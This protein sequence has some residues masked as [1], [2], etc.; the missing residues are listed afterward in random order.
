MDGHHHHS[1]LDAFGVSL[2]FAAAFNCDSMLMVVLFC[3]KNVTYWLSCE[4]C[5]R[6]DQNDIP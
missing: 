3:S 6:P 1:V 5:F 4:S 2:S